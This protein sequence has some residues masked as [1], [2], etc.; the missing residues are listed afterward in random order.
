MRPVGFAL[1]VGRRDAFASLRLVV[2][3]PRRFRFAAAG[4][5][6]GSTV[7]FAFPAV[8]FLA[9]GDD[10]FSRFVFGLD[11]RTGLV[12]RRVEPDVFVDLSGTNEDVSID[13]TNV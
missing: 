13:G 1:R 2:A 7:G 5:F 3:L 9:P 6:A 4:F 10:G 8:V 12:D 11:E